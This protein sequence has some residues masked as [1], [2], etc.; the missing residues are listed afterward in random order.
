MQP[1][2]I[3]KNKQAVL[4]RPKFVQKWILRSE[5]QTLLRIRNQFF[6]DNMSVNFEANET[7]LIFSI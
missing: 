2:N 7:I 4:F 3:Q 6:Q 1:K 5:F